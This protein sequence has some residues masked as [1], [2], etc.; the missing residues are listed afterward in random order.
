MK[1]KTNLIAI[2]AASI[3]SLALLSGCGGSTEKK[4]ITMWAGGQWTSTDGEN[5]KEFITE[6]N[7]SHDL[8][9]ELTIK[10]EFETQFASAITV[11]RQPDLVVWDR[12]NTPTYQQQG[13]LYPI[14]DLIAQDSIDTSMFQTQ[15]YKELSYEG[16]QYGLPLDLDIWGIYVNNDIL[17]TYN[18]AN[19]DNQAV[20]PST[21]DELLDTAKKLTK[22]SDGTIAQAGYSS[23]DM[24][25]H[26]FKFMVS[27]GTSFLGEDGYPDYTTDAAKKTIEYFKTI[28]NANVSNDGNSGKEDFKNGR[29]AMINQPVYFSSY[30]KENAPDLNYTFIP[31]PAMSKTEGKQGGMIGGFGFA[32]PNPLEKNQTDSWKSK[33]KLAWSFMK[34]WLTSEEMQLSWSKKSNTLP[35]LK[36]VYSTDW[37]QSTPVLKA[38][39]SY[40]DNY[41]CRPSL[42]GFYYVQVNVYDDYLKSWI[43]G[44][45]SLTE[46]ALLL[47]L[48][49]ETRRVV[50][51]YKTSK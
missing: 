16:H 12:W 6:Y 29:L 30:L 19:A 40:I 32:L 33:Q 23:R 39:A 7:G 10:T 4:T 45:S 24:Y 31:Q 15:A 17:N 43:K 25:E 49:S 18:T 5:L 35:A 20:L 21:W 28:Y 26:Y 9:V 22:T 44:D 50:D 34:E 27:T 47:K 13:F 8:Q 37:V 51:S 1:K 38:A 3:F 36:S 14:D 46:E 41:E 2:S 48:D 11:G 42:P